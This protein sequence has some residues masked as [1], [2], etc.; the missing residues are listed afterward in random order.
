MGVSE[1]TP[2]EILA[3]EL[4]ALADANRRAGRDRLNTAD[5]ADHLAVEGR[6]IA[7]RLGVE[8]TEM[9]LHYL[10]RQAAWVAVKPGA[11]TNRLNAIRRR[12]AAS[13]Q[14]TF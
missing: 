11:E 14:K 8:V 3:A 9:L 4:R 1:F 13:G 6:G 2:E 7:D 12:K 5:L 10:A